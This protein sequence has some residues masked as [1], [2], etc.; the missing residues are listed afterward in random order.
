MGKSGGRCQ[1]SLDPERVLNGKST[2]SVESL[3]EL[4]REVNPTD[5]QMP[6]PERRQRYELKSALQSLL[7]RRFADQLCV[8]PDD[9]N[10]GVVLLRHRSQPIQ[11]GHAIVNEL[12]DDAR[13]WVQMQL[14]LG[15]GVEPDASASGIDDGPRLD[16]GVAAPPQA[17]S[18]ADALRVG[19]DALEAYDFD[20]ARTFFEEAF[21]S[22]R[23]DEPAAT[24]LVGLL[25]DHL[26]ADEEAL[27]LSNRLSP[28]ASRSPDLRV[29]LA[30]AAQRIGNAAA[31][32]DWLRGVEN[33]RAVEMLEVIGSGAAQRGDRALAEAAMVQIRLRDDRNAAIARV[34]LLIREHSAREREPEEVEIQRQMQAGAWKQAEA[35]SRELLQK[36]PDSAVARQ[37][38]RAVDDRRREDR[39]KTALQEAQQFASSG[40]HQEVVRLVREVLGLGLSDDSMLQ[41]AHSL[42]DQAEARIEAAK[43]KAQVEQ[44]LGMLS[45][46]LT[47][48]AARAFLDVNPALRAC[49][50]ERTDV[51]EL[52][53]LERAATTRGADLNEAVD[54]VLTFL[55]NRARVSVDPSGFLAAI[56]PHERL[57]ATVKDAKDSIAAARRL[58]SEQ[59]SAA[60]V[61]ALRAA[62]QKMQ[63]S[64]FANA[65]S[66]LDAVEVATLPTSER[67]RFAT[68]RERLVGLQD[69]ESTEERFT[70]LVERSDLFAA[71]DLAE[72]EHE[73][74]DTSE[75][76]KWA[77]RAAL[78]QQ[79]IHEHWHVRRLDEQTAKGVIQPFQLSVLSGAA[80]RSVR[81][82][83]N[84]VALAISSGC[85][86]FVAEL[87]IA[88]GTV[89][90]RMAFRTPTSMGEVEVTAEGPDLWLI[91]EDCAVMIEPG[92]WSIRRW[93]HLKSHSNAKVIE[94][95]LVLLAGGKTL[96][97]ETRVQAESATTLHVIDTG[98]GLCK[99]TLEGCS[100]LKVVVGA[101]NPCA[102]V[103]RRGSGLAVID[104][105]GAALLSFT[106]VRE[107]PYCVATRPDRA[108][109]VVACSSS[110]NDDSPQLRLLV[111]NAAGRLDQD[112]TIDNSAIASGTQLATSLAA[113]MVFAWV[114]NAESGQPDL[115]GFRW[116]ADNLLVQSFRVSIP[117]NAT[118]VQDC[119]AERVFAAVCT[120]EG[121][122]LAELGP[123]PPALLGTSVD[124]RN[125]PGLTMA[126]T[127]CHSAH[128][129]VKANSL[130]L[131]ASLQ[132]LE[133]LEQNR[134]IRAIKARAGDGILELLALKDA[135]YY[136]CRF[137]EAKALL[138]WI[139]E[140]HPNNAVARTDLAKWH[141]TGTDW[142]QLQEL[143]EPIAIE[144]LPEELLRHHYH[145]LGMAYAAAGNSEAALV[146]FRSGLEHDG[147]CDLMSWIDMV[148]A[149]SDLDCDGWRSPDQSDIRQ[150]VAML[151]AAD[152][153]VASAD[154]DSALRTLNNGLL[155]FSREIQ[156]SARMA[157]VVLRRSEVGRP[158]RATEALALARFCSLHSDKGTF[159]RELALSR[160]FRWSSEQLDDLAQ[161]AEQ[162]L[163]R[164]E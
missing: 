63:A 20:G 86:V 72:Q 54:A 83:A 79:R 84:S 100:T 77:D 24:A 154:L 159:R 142:A 3:M 12:E 134:E 27:A 31:A 35:L 103:Q 49:I 157:D 74:S 160:P 132:R 136:L 155:W 64:E 82:E 13:A 150:M 156:S 15:V 52:A 163:E 146:A 80:V 66:V 118:L 130:A 70:L 121:I 140:R 120:S 111:L 158:T 104:A 76:Q 32:L 127:S 162:W 91:G 139:A 85:W 110:D 18:A 161:R 8:E 37:C 119:A 114:I 10:E 11:A 1:G 137:D 69:R 105:R 17:H 51:P 106:A 53:W 59:R 131:F 90:Y 34:Q 81:Q 109:Y 16:P 28:E 99:R 95:D 75:G 57:L 56:A 108:G 19:R 164:W 26:G 97:L 21:R 149:G 38:L 87:D 6:K 7:V 50:R 33:L 101:H 29:L 133:P 113:Q 92:H 45:A 98:T 88:S 138:D 43:E 148:G 39:A 71:R 30:Q 122:E 141:T 46:G 147:A 153:Y 135:L 65:L 5:R 78:L 4:I 112:I 67:E 55:S 23:G 41:A 102:L 117:L 36:H 62:E 73:H 143:L 44:V 151:R 126:A 25:V 89:S 68:L 124:R 96:V 145:V 42:L 116:G 48:R 128:P 93:L 40:S 60:A 107:F 22:T 125:L 47:E 94:E 152:A 144:E 115:L 2:V 129:E 14:D 61:D 123:V 58:V 9:R